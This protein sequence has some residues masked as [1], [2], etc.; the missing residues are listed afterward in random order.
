MQAS[1]EAKKYI[2]VPDIRHNVYIKERLQTQED[3]LIAKQCA[4]AKKYSI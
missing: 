1:K 2:Y 4:G 3:A